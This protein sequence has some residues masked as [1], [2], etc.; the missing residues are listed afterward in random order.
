MYARIATYLKPNFPV[1]QLLMGGEDISQHSLSRFFMIH[2]MLLPLLTLPV[3]GLH[4][5]IIPAR[6][7]AWEAGSS[8]PAYASVSTI[9]PTA[10]RPPTVET[11]TRPRRWRATSPTGRA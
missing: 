9:R 6:V 8:G 11:I 1:A 10:R 5:W 3:L 7:A 2:I 4:L